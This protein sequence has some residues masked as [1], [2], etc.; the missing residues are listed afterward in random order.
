M[1]LRVCADLY[2]HCLYRWSS[3]SVRF[4]ADPHGFCR[5]CVCLRVR[6][7][8][9]GHCLYQ[10]YSISVRV[11]AGPHGF[12]LQ[13]SCG[14]VRLCTDVCACLCR[15]TSQ[16]V[17]GEHGIERK[18][19][20]TLTIIS[21]CRVRGSYCVINSEPVVRLLT[22]QAGWVRSDNKTCHQLHRLS[23]VSDFPAITC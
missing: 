2:G 3:I 4:H 1:S 10:W 13:W 7:D 18:A 21:R 11:R 6:A 15:R 23:G 12:L 14:Y 16:S 19:R 9:C 20:Q 17:S 5:S 8:L 22:K